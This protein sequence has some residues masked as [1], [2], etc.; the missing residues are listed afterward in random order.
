MF[1]RDIATSLQ[2]KEHNKLASKMPHRARLHDHHL[3]KKRFRAPPVAM[4]RVCPSWL[5]SGDD[6]LH[7]PLPGLTLEN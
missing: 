4:R 1:L 6:G 7:N 2:N 3:K 5:V